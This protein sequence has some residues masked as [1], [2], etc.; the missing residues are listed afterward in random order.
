MSVRIPSCE[1]RVVFLRTLYTLI[2]DTGKALLC[3]QQWHEGVVAE[4][5]VALGYWCS[6]MQAGLCDTEAACIL[7]W[8]P[9]S[10]S[11][12]GVCVSSLQDSMHVQLAAS[13]CNRMA[14]LGL[15]GAT[16]PLEDRWLN[17]EGDDMAAHERGEGE[18]GADYG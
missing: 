2:H 16:L 12:H 9:H 6:S 1:D 5:L 13:I 14:A 15:P 3:W 4:L 10:I 17:E 11:S 18:D 8:A 7:S